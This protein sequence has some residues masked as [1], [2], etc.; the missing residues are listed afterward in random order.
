MNFEKFQSYQDDTSKQEKQKE[1]KEIKLEP[2]TESPKNRR[3]FLRT[4]LGFGASTVLT[5]GIMKVL[6][7]WDDS[8][9]IEKNIQNIEEKRVV[10]V[11]RKQPMFDDNEFNNQETNNEK[12]EDVHHIEIPRQKIDWI[13]FKKMKPNIPS[14]REVAPPV[15]IEGLRLPNDISKFGATTLAGKIMRTVRFK[16]V[17]D[18]VEDRYNLPR[19]VLLAMI[20]EESTGVDL[21]PNALGDGGFGLCHMQGSTAREFGLKTFEGCNALVCNGKD[22]RSCVDT[23]GNLLNHANDL[24]RFINAHK[25]DRKKLIEADERLHILLNID[26]AGRMLAMGISGPPLKGRLASLNPLERAIARYAGAYNYQAYWKDIQKN[27]AYLNDSTVMREIA[28][29][30]DSH[31]PQLKIDNQKA[32][33]VMYIKKVQEQH[34]NFGL[35]EYKRL[36]KY[37]PINSEIVLQQYTKRLRL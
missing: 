27:M 9:N 3:E 10:F 21:L 29:Q 12:K 15:R 1:I 11:R 24:A 7:D 35:Q 5:G 28:E 13:Q 14:Y 17:T 2:H 4:I 25:F 20:M 8:K 23:R 30:F 32:N 19:G 16:N 31:N 33:F 37:N 6:P 18:A 34:D 36:E 22:K 26:A